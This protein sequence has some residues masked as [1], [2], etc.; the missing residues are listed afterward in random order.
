[1][2]RAVTWTEAAWKDLEEI[3]DYLARD[4]R[5]YAAAFI[6]EMRDAAL[7]LSGFAERGRVVPE[8][9]DPAIRELFV[10]RYRLIYRITE[11]TVYVLGIIHGARYLSAL[12]E[13]EKRSIPENIE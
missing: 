8:I 6:R 7:S 9:S 12:W 13:R 10:R 2:A 5:S 3:A 4:S 11:H 1:M